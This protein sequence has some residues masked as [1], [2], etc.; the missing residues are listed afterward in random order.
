MNNK[1]NILAI[2][3]LLW[4]LLF[5]PCV[6]AE[7]FKWVDEKGTTHFTED[8][9][10]IPEKYRQQVEKRPTKEDP[11][12]PKEKAKTE[13]Q[14]RKGSAKQSPKEPPRESPKEP[15]E[16]ER[17]NVRRIELDVADA[18]KNIISL[19]KDKKFDALYDCGDRKSHTSMAREDFRKRM[20][21]KGR[22][23]ATSWETVRDI[24]VDVRNA[25]QAYVTARIGYRPQ[26]GG[27]TRIRTE[28]FEMKFENG[29][30]RINLTKV[31]APSK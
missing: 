22:E 24:K 11:G 5:L 3:T 16:K 20:E 26:K 7:I 8:E 30:W 17:V 10:A 1:I 15:K 28:T 19:W 21:G 27:E 14:E 13:K 29:T 9:S 4:Q 18:F 25:T 31:L 23:L 6:S 12:S 2:L